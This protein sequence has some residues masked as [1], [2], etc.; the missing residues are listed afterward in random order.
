MQIACIEFAR[1]VLGL[2]RAN[3]TE[4][5]P[6]T[7]HP[8]ICLLEEQKHIDRKG[9]TMRLGAMPCVVKKGTKTYGVYG[10]RKISERHRHRF[11]FNNAYREQFEENGIIFSGVFEKQNLVEIIELKDHPWYVGC[12]FHPEFQS[13][14]NRPHPLFR[15]FIRAALRQSKR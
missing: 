15:G 1:N 4:F 3:S 14:P 8:V 6:K 9:G 13:K 12:Q 10:Q 11:E 7:A 5:S 2:R